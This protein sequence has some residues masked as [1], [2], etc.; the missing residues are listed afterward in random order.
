MSPLEDPI[1]VTRTRA[2]RCLVSYAADRAASRGRQLYLDTT[3]NPG[4]SLWPPL[5]ES[6]WAYGQRGG[7]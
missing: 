3:R 7:T 2:S 5:P 4:L 1:L 6:R